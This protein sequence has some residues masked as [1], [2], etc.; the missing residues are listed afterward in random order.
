[1]CLSSSW[2]FAPLGDGA[3]G[4]KGGKGVVLVNVLCNTGLTVVLFML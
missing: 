3:L 2:G 4:R 1:M